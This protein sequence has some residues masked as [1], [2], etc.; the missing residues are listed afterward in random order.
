MQKEEDSMMWWPI[1][2]MSPSTM[3][4]TNS[5]YSLFTLGRLVVRGACSTSRSIIG[6]EATTQKHEPIDCCSGSVAVDLHGGLFFIIKP[7]DSM[8]GHNNRGVHGHCV[9]VVVAGPLSSA[10]VGV[11]H[12]AGKLQHRL[13]L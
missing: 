13:R 4:K 12:I 11:G 7:V 10:A 9:R 5:C 3:T 2:L 8:L 1:R 6:P